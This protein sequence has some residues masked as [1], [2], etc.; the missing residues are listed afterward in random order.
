M[1]RTVMFSEIS[2][3]CCIGFSLLSHLF[4]QHVG[5]LAPADCAH[6]DEEGKRSPCPLGTHSV[7]GRLPRS[8]EYKC[9]KGCEA[10]PGAQG[11]PPQGNGLEAAS[12]PRS[13]SGQECSRRVEKR[14]QWLR[15]PRY[16]RA[17]PSAPRPRLGMWAWVLQTNVSKARHFKRC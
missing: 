11:R 12:C 9:G 3:A 1:C 4:N 10:C 2:Y 15:E 6:C 5:R 16:I 14:V 17:G 8:S 7:L 13:C